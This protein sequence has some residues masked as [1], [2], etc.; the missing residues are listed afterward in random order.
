MQPARAGELDGLREVDVALRDGSH[1]TVRPIAPQDAD[2]LRASFERLSEESRYRRFLSPIH[3]L[4]GPMLRYLTDVDHR[5]H[6]ALVAVRADGTLVGVARAVR[7]RDNPQA[8]EVAVTVAD[9]WQGRGLGTALL[10]LLAER[11]R[12]MGITR[13]T[14][15]VLITNREM[16]EL[17]QQLG[18]IHIIERSSGTTE[19]EI[20]LPP[21]GAGP[22]LSELMRGS[23]SGRY[24]V[25]ASAPKVPQP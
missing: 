3:K 18:P 2:A 21:E 19:L 17:F 10:G 7:L 9:D 8:A 6:E 14:A 4:S 22:H 12:A 15:L 24:E 11:A 1:V 25:V 20:T 5:D 13:F 16:L 23:A